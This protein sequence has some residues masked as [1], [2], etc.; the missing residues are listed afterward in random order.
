MKL[1][2]FCGPGRA[3]PR[4]QQ[5]RSEA[6]R[7]GPIRNARAAER[8]HATQHDALLVLQQPMTGSRASSESVEASSSAGSSRTGSSEPLTSSPTPPSQQCWPARPL[9]SELPVRA[10][11]TAFQALTYAP[12]DWFDPSEAT[13]EMHLVSGSPSVEYDRAEDF[14]AT[15]Q[16]SQ[17][18]EYIQPDGTVSQSPSQLSGVASFPIDMSIQPLFSLT[19]VQPSRIRIPSTFEAHLDRRIGRLWDSYD[20]LT[21][22]MP[23]I[24]ETF[25]RVFCGLLHQSRV[26]AED[27]VRTVESVFLKLVLI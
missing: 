16:S 3:A 12:G 24:S 15:N 17:S 18:S 22:A 7:E 5:G 1:N 23:G 2:H 26:M 9:S 20:D 10:R 11:K 27:G 19:T 21:A 14:H 25:G 8:L 6:A 13:S 4:A